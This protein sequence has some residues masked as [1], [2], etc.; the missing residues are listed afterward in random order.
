MPMP[1]DATMKDLVQ[2]FIHDYE[3]QIGLQEFL[4]LTVLNAD[5]STVTAATDIALGHGDPPDRVVDLNF[6][7]GP[8]ED[9][10]ARALLYNA[11]LHYRYRVPVH[12]IIILLRREA[13]HPNLTRHLRYE[14]RKRKGKMDFTYRSGPHVGTAAAAV[15]AG[16]SGN[17]AAG[18]ALP[19][20]RGGH[21][22][23][24][25][26]TGNPARGATTGE[27]S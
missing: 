11:L 27:R 22:R 26:S 5:L 9:L 16:W 14:G 10:S 19:A 18:A 4:P 8:A 15:L 21:D 3:V 17:L 24:G 13:D 25:A 7:S 12:S 2:T 6:Q 23:A 1:F 20:A